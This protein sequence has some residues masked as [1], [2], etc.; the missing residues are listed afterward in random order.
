M[1]WREVLDECTRGVRSIMDFIAG[2]D[3]PKDHS[4][5]FCFLRPI[6]IRRR[7]EFLPPPGWW[8]GSHWTTTSEDRQ[9]LSRPERE[10]W[11]RAEVNQS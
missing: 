1:D 11:E 2:P 10:A 3:E 9:F 5:D 6:W 8:S 7:F 4:K